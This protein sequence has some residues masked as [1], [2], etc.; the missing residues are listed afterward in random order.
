MENMDKMEN[1]REQESPRAL[2]TGNS[3]DYPAGAKI[4]KR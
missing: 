2:L 1:L 4:L 3:H